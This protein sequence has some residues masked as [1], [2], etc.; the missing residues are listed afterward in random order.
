MRILELLFLVFR[1]FGEQRNR[2]VLPAKESA[3]RLLKA[4]A[5]QQCRPGVLFPPALEISIAIASRAAQVLS[6]LGIAIGHRRS[7]WL[8]AGANSSQ[9]AAGA[10]PSKFRKE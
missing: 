4:A 1:P 2:A 10:N 5:E 3:K 9:S 6:D 8:V 7:S